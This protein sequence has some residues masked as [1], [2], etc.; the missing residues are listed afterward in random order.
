MLGES[1]ILMEVFNDALIKNRYGFFECMRS[2]SRT[3]GLVE[4]ERMYGLATLIYAPDIT[5]FSGKYNAKGGWTDEF[6][7]NND[8]EDEDDD[9]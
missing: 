4:R 9:D 8:D 3:L 5:D 2:L 7:D 1:L 6:A